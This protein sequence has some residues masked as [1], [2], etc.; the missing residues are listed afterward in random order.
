MEHLTTE[1]K[2]IAIA[3]M[4]E[5]FEIKE[6]EGVTKPDKPYWKGTCFYLGRADNRWSCGSGDK[7]WVR[8]SL[9]NILKFDSDA[10]WQFEALDWID[11]QPDLYG[12]KGH[13]EIRIGM[14]MRDYSCY[15]EFHVQTGDK[16]HTIERKVN[17]YD[18]SSRKEAIFEVLY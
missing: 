15:I 6:W 13:Y 4:L 7:E 18:A 5:A 10:N 11:K 12:R 1:Q 2:N 3:E 17:I 9:A 16:S 14:W 8:K